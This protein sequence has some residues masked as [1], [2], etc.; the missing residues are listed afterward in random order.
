MSDEKCPHCQGCVN[1]CQRCQCCGKCIRCGKAS[2]F[3]SPA[4]NPLPWPQV[5]YPVQPAPF[6]VPTDPWV[7]IGPAP[8]VTTTWCGEWG[9][10][11]RFGV[12]AQ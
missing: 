5:P 9:S 10:D 8:Y 3:Y 4:I 12:Q 2:A 11:F 6:V 7:G 1:G